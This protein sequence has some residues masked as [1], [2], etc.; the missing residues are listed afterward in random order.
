MYPGLINNTTIDWFMRWPEDALF[1]V[2]KKF[3]QAIDV[4]EEKKDALAQLCCYKHMTVIDHAEQMLVE[5]RRIYYVTPS[6]YIELLKGYKFMISQ[7]KKQ[8]GDQVTKLRNGLSKLDDARVQVEEMT[9]ES[10]IKRAEVSKQQ[11][12]C[13]ELMITVEAEQRIADEQ[14]KIIETETTKIAKEKIETLKMA[15][16]AENEL[17]KAEPALIS[18]EESLEKLDKKYIAEIKSFPS[19]PADVEMVMYA[20]MVILDKIQTWQTVKKE[21]AD[22]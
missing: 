6:N 14:R 9:A 16:D 7:K 10:E 4:P 19:P 12:V 11:K 15:A 2:A 20:V 13:E 1:E 8:I 5:L 17:K 18:A 21:L 22:P 3:L